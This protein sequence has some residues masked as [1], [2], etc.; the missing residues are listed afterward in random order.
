M[1]IELTLL[2][3]VSHQGQEITAPRLRGLLALLAGELRAGCG[4]GRLVDGLW[5]DEQPENPVKALQILVSRAR[6]RLGAEVIASTPS[7]YRLALRE[8]QVDASAV[9]LFAAAGAEKARAGDHPGALAEAEEGLRLWDGAPA[10]E[11]GTF[12]DPVGELRAE[13]AVTYRAL[14]RCRALSLARTGRRD[15]AAGPLAELAA[16]R[17]HDEELLL[18]LMRCQ[19]AAAGPAAALA[20]YDTHRRRL[21]DELGTDPGPALQELHQELLRGEAPVVRRGVPH[22]P[23]PLLGRDADIAAV[24]RLLHSARVT[25]VV[26]PG[27]LGKTRLASAVARDAEQRVVHLVPLAGVRRDADVAAE[28]ASALGAGESLRPA[29]GGEA[30][31]GIVGALGSGPALLVLDNCEQVVGGVADLVRA[32]VSR[33]RDLRVLTTSRAPLGLT[34]ETV[35]PLPELDLATTVELFEQ[36][37]R[38]AR[39]D[40]DLPA[41]SV[42]ALCRR[43]DG[44]PLA[45]ELAAARVR[46][47]SVAEIARRLEDR[48]ALLRGGP[49]DVPQRHRTLQAVVDWSW[50][51]LDEEG[52]SALRALSAFPDGFT[53]GAA[54][55]LADT[56][57]A[58][59]VLADLVDQSL[60]KV[61]D[62]GYGTRFRMLETVREF[63]AAHRERAGEEAAVTERFLGWAREFGVVHHDAPFGPDPL[64]SWQ[65]VRAEQD[66]LVHALRLALAREDLDTVAAVTAVLGAL[67]TTEANYPRLIALTEDCARPLSHYRP[68]PA[69]V[70]PA[71]TAAAL[72]AA[73]LFLGVGTGA[74][75]TL[76]TLRR[77]PSAEPDTLV[78]AVAAVLCAF[79][80][81]LTDRNALAELCA[82]KKPLLAGVAN[83]V[84]SYVAESGQRPDLALAAARRMVELLGDRDIPLLRIWP[85]SRLAELCL[86]TERGAEA[87][88]H[89][90]AA[91]DALESLGEWND[92]I[93]MRW[94]LMLAHLQT[95]DLDTAE[96][97]LEE[98]LR[99][100][101]EGAASDAFTPDLGARAEMALARGD[102]ETGLGLWRRA[103]ERLDNGRAVPVFGDELLMEG[104]VLE[105]QSVALVAH[106]RH[107]RTDL[108]A[109]LAAALPRRLTTL[110]T[111]PRPAPHHV[112]VEYPVCGAL[113]LALGTVA[114]AD[115][116]SGR[117][118]RLTA[119]AERF[120][121]LRNFQPSMSSARAREAARNAD[122]AAY[123]DAVSTYAALDGDG[124]REVALGLVRDGLTA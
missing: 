29:A 17:P 96:H 116:E 52:R 67:W 69:Y 15:E 46:V 95:G 82:A 110:L 77:L 61:T 7:G 4:A 123:E 50:N 10:G 35:Y 27:G 30:I 63:A 108:V 43:L 93:G 70:E 85:A 65:L 88:V 81:V 90:R 48:F 76:V 62:T 84:A 9:L 51:L 47:M 16:D 53:A 75:R 120:R 14:V 34:S 83:C 8:D 24:T 103:L 124:L 28:V 94:G 114:L 71:R 68:G 21:R 41:D 74:V 6:R 26:G 31:A 1:T 44:L 104:W 119:L 55:Q 22:E 32:L 13:R 117:G 56:F 73:N 59:E 79:P 102:T 78:R 66:N 38:A 23:N 37:A 72:L 87:L 89:L 36:R 98:A 25:S 107:G 57:D 3:S 99:H 19:T 39:P 97:W 5:P 106:A 122:R 2:S 101:P 105:L 54:E 58:L 12:G 100:Q 20:T 45:T 64:S 11:T 113:L 91:L 112:T 118:A 42:A 80:Q 115:G 109:P 18:E 33:T 86:Q 60:L 92:A 49:R 40:V 121:A 111:R